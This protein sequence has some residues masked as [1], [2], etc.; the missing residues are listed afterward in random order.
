MLRRLRSDA[1][2][3]ALAPAL[4]QMDIA[5]PS[6]ASRFHTILLPYSLVT[7]LTDPR[8]ATQAIVAL[9]SLLE[10]DGCLVLDAFIPKPVTSFADFREDYR[11]PHGQGVLERHKR[12]GANADGTN[13]IERRYRIYRVDGTL[14]SEFFTD[15]T[16]RPC[17][18]TDLAALGASAGLIIERWSHDY[19][20]SSSADGARFATVVLRAPFPR[21]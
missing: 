17:A 14:E 2:L 18:P 4:V 6:L 8:E 13:R 7:Y 3:H 12:I 1:Q 21:T 16:I 11:R 15:E 19:D 5:R 20:A 10:P 9:A